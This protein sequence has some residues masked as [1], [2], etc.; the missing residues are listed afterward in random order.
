M[1]ETFKPLAWDDLRLVKA[2]AEAGSLPAAAGRLGLNHST[3]FRRLGQIEQALGVPLFERHRTGYVP[4]PAGEEIAALAER[5]DSDVTG[6]VRRLAGR[7]P[8]PAGELRV[9]TND[10]LLIHLLTP[11]F[12]RFLATFPDIGLDVV[13]DNQALNLSRRDADV[14]IR[15]TD[16]PPDTLVGRRAARIAWA[17]YGR[18]SDF[19]MPQAVDEDMLASCRWV[20]LGDNMGSLKAVKFVKAAIAPDRVAY[21]VNTVLGLAE[22]VEGGI[23]IG[24]LPCFIAD[25]RPSLTRLAPPDPAFSADLWLL[26]HPDLRHAAR[27]RALLDFLA[28]EIGAFRSVIEGRSR[29]GYGT[30]RGE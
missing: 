11:L 17:L 12:A 1:T 22:A 8:A 2:V 15:A 27:V 29:D 24:H 7:E 26:T 3:V 13:L 9:T 30:E 14:A 10:S 6:V 5:V 16:E 4:T 20:S 25:I 23:G 18:A 28:A 21:K 19:P